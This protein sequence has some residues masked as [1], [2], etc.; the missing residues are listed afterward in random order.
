MRAMPSTDTLTRRPADAVA[1][2]ERIVQTAFATLPS[3]PAAQPCWA[4][5]DLLGPGVEALIHHGEA[6]YRLRLTR[7]GKLILTK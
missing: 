7:Q 3:A 5:R 1:H 6:V 2:G 4:S